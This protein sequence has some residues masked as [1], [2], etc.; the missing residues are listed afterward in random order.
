VRF[1]VVILPTWVTGL[2]P[3]FAEYYRN[4]LAPAL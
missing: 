4:L 3:P 1:D 2:D